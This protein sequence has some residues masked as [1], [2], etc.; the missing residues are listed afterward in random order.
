MYIKAL[1][2][3]GMSALELFNNDGVDLLK[4]FI[5]NY[6]ESKYKHIINFKLGNYYY[7][8]KDYTDA[9]AYYSK[10]T[11]KDLEEEFRNE[12]YFKV[13]YSNF[14]L[15]NNDAAR[16]AFVEIKDGDSQYANPAL[17][18][19]SHIAYTDKNYQTA[20]DGF[21]KLEGDESFGKVVPYYIL[22]IYYLRLLF[23]KTVLR[24][25]LDL[26]LEEKLHHLS[27]QK[28]VHT[29]RDPF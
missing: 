20:L 7:R 9:L 22:Q 16:N 13:G 25:A 3:E 6:P 2:Y 1:Y 18:Y 24:L 23:Y 28:L 14:Q 29:K 27:I 4:R 12:Y 21:L 19:F 8:S 5:M 10:F 11:A 26:R 17:Y 15:G